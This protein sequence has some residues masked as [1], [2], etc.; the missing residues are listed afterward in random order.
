MR[1]YYVRVSAPLG[2][3]ELRRPTV[4]RFPRRMMPRSWT[5]SFWFNSAL[6]NRGNV[7][8][9]ANFAAIM[10]RAEPEPCE[11]TWLPGAE[12]AFAGLTEHCPK[13]G[14]EQ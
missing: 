5:C 1:D 3:I 9:K 7:S 12:G 2:R 11:H 8:R 13:C 10:N 4:V 14:C 6:F